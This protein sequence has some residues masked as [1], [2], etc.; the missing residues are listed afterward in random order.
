MDTTRRLFVLTLTI[1]RPMNSRTATIRDI[2]EAL[3]VSIG[4]VD[5]ALNDRAGVNPMTK[6]RV[7]Q[8]AKTLGYRP[9][10]AARF[11]SSRR[12]VRISINIPVE[13]AS[14]WAPVREGVEEEAAPFTQAGL[15]LEFRRFPKLG[16]GEEEAFE[17][18]LSSGV[19]GIIAAIGRPQN[20]RPFIRRASR[21]R[22]PVVCVVTDAPG[23]E[24]LGVVSIDPLISGAL[25]GELLGRFTSSRGT[26]GVITGD[27][28]IADHAEKHA[29]FQ[30]ALRSLFPAVQVAE[31]IEN[32]EDEAEAYE[33]CRALLCSCSDISGLYVSTANSGPVLRAVEDLGALGNITVL[34]TDLFPELVRH[35][36][37]GDVVASLYQRPRSQGRLALRMLRSYL[38]EGKCPAY[39]VRLAP[40]L[41]MKSNLAQFLQQISLETDI[42]DGKQSSGQRASN[43][44]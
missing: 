6:E 32:H 1:S 35:I 25:A 37:A 3:G 22:I 2:A 10:L 38:I 43:A 16:S 18:A 28:K 14:F 39:Q 17:A 12:R 34:T 23:T 11:L 13:I 27:L 33:K 4:T 5:R 21:S 20:L 26:L 7:L 19:D 40:H 41:V 44:S 31:P 8:M 29:A 15:E 30:Q 24:R 36:D 9:N 42:E